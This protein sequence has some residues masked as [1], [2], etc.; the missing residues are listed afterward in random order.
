MGTITSITQEIIPGTEASSGWRPGGELRFFMRNLLLTWLCTA[1]AVGAPCLTAGRECTEWVR[2]G[3]RGA[4]S[5]IYRSYPLAERN[6]A[7]ERAL[8]MVHGASRDADNYFRTA[9]AAAF[10]A[11]ALN[12]TMLIAPRYASNDG[13]GCR[14]TLAADELNWPCNGNSW[15]SGGA[16]AQDRTL[17]SYDLMDDIL[18]KLANRDVFPNL[19]EIV[20]AG[21]SAGGQ[22]VTRYEMANLVHEKLGVPVTYVVANPSSYAYPDATRPI[23]G[24]I[25]CA[26]Y[27]SWPYGLK[28]RRGY[29]ER[30]TD[31]QLKKQMA[32]RP[33]TYL[34][35]EI[36]ILPL[37]GF[38]GS[39]AA[40]AQGPTRLAR[41]EAFGKYVDGKYGA[42]HK[43]QEVN[44]CG[45]NARC[46][47]TAD[48]ALPVIFPAVDSVSGK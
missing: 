39:C 20:V 2:L 31:E 32:S 13:R 44:L 24:R 27:D 7:I 11:G 40:M 14:D 47:F 28:N 29:A 12:N 10:L 23:R 6:E 26:D 45:H 36:D 42:K 19:K 46:M 48:E 37:G 33:V 43:I 41:G 21:H 4:G 17:T 34:L 9:M 18:K 1:T 38:D 16:A 3:D 25:R 22:F 35:G 30:L 15:R 5:L 8:V